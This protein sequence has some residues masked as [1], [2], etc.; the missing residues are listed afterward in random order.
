MSENKGRSNF[1]L[2]DEMEENEMLESRG[3]G[4]IE[5]WTKPRA[6]QGRVYELLRKVGLTPMLA[7]GL[8]MLIPCLFLPPVFLAAFGFG[9][10]LLVFG[11]FEKIILDRSEKRKK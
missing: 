2:M 8:V 5:R 9:G 11:I 6:Y 10:V 4:Y 3:T 7:M 1:A